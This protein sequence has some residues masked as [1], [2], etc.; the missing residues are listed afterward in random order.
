VR[1]SATNKKTLENKMRVL[2]F[3]SL[4]ASV[5]AFI[6][7]SLN[8]PSAPVQSRS[9]N[10]MKMGIMD[11]AFADE[12]GVDTSGY[13][14]YFDPLGLTADGDIEKFN[15]VRAI[16]I[17]HG[18]I[19][20]LAMTHVFV[21][22]FV[23]LPGMLSYSKG[24]AFAD[25]PSG[26]AAL[27]V[28]PAAGWFQIVLFQIALEILAPQDPEKAPGDVQ[29]EPSRGKYFKRYDDDDVRKKKLTIELNNGRLAMMAIAGTW[30]SD[31][32]TG[33]QDPIDVLLSK[34]F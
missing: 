23:K 2:A 16:E 34:F 22:H 7:S 33:S 12:P 9:R 1:I 25:V 15:R 26:L 30:A 20:M 4:L 17:K 29:P 24:I 3:L 5:A 11:G 19:A 14:G 10:V 6:P 28:V 13:I 31:A 27:K 21:T 18:R 32:L 8:T